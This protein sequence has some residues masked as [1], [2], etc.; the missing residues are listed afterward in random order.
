MTPNPID[1]AQQPTY[2]FAW[3]ATKWLV[4]PSTTPGA[5]LTFG[6][7]VLLPG[8]GHERHNHEGAEEVL[9]VLSGEGTQTVADGEP[10][11]VGSVWTT[12]D[13]LVREAKPTTAYAPAA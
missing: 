2:T 9:Y 7:V 12:E 5:K 11:A 6:E 4:T 3:G 10:F 8:K 13:H 1:R